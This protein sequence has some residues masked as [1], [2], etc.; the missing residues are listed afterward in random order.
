MHDPT[1]T[2]TAPPDHARPLGGPGRGP[3]RGRAWSVVAAATL[4]AAIGPGTIMTHGVLVAALAGATIAGI[5]AGAVLVALSAVLQFGLGPAIGAATERHGIRIVVGAGALLYGGGAAAAAVAIGLG[6][7]EL[8]VLVYAVGTGAAGAC[9]LAP[10]FATVA[11]WFDRRRAAAVGIVTAGS[12]LGALVLAPWLARLLE[13]DGLGRLW[14]VVAVV[15]GLGLA[16]AAAALR[17]PP[18]M[19]PRGPR[20]RFRTVWADPPLRRFYLAGVLGSTGMFAAMTYLVPFARSLGLGAAAAA[21]LLGL[22]GAVSIAS[23]LAVGVV[24]AAHVYRVYRGSQVVLGATGVLWWA[25]VHRDG[26]LLAFVVLYGLAA[27]AWSALAPLVVAEAHADRL[28]SV[29]GVLYTSPGIGGALGP[30]A[31]T[32][33]LRVGPMAAVGFFLAVCFLAAV[34]VLRPLTPLAIGGRP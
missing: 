14:A 8:A 16:S 6:Q 1:S 18:Q 10:L 2:V 24:P 11:G 25:A 27:G 7:L 5:T 22:T 9:T 12:G 31:V 4:A 19:P 28:A 23:R 34:R 20:L 29:L 15:G 33:L 30:L 13:R 21:S 26:A 3:G 32:A 17:P